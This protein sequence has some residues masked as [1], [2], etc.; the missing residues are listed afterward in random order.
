MGDEWDYFP[1]IEWVDSYWGDSEELENP[2]IVEADALKAVIEKTDELLA[3]E[4]SGE[5]LEDALV[6]FMDEQFGPDIKLGSDKYRRD[7]VE[8]EIEIVDLFS[9]SP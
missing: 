2:I 5:E 9:A 6:T 7:L 8:R 3:V 1:K 4:A